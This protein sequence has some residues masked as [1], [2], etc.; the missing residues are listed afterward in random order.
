[1]KF[2]IFFYLSWMLYNFSSGTKT[3]VLSSALADEPHTFCSYP[4]RETD[5]KLRRCPTP[6]FLRAVE[7]L[8]LLKFAMKTTAN[9]IL[10]IW[11]P[12]EQGGVPLHR[13]KLR[14]HMEAGVLIR[15]RTGQRWPR[16]QESCGTTFGPWCTPQKSIMGLRNP[17]VP[18]P[19]TPCENND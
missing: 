6:T 9:S 11:K 15:I 7:S 17:L 1:M 2:A 8:G 10:L 13:P 4:W 19:P 3:R 5:F 16:A 14:W 18:S 12:M